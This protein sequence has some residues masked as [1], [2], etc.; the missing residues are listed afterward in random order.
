[1]VFL[2]LIASLA[3]RG[4]N[5]LFNLGDARFFRQACPV[6]QPLFGIDGLEILHQTLQTV[7]AVFGLQVALMLLLQ[8]RQTTVVVVVRRPEI[9]LI[10]VDVRDAQVG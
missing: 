4:D 6:L 8:G 7:A 1:L 9:V 3:V 2:L 10:V 5:P